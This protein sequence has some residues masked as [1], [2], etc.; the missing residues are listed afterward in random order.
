MSHT[1]E[2]TKEQAELFAQALDHIDQTATLLAGMPYE[3]RLAWLKAH[4]YCRPI[5]F[6]RELCG[7][8]YTVHAHF[9][10]KNTETVERKAERI[11]CKSA[12]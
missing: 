11:I 10:E 2:L 3:A 4:Q 6:E 8:L 1:I 7:T 12:L 9:S 5:S